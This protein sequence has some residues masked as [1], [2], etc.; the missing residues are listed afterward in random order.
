M[1]LFQKKHTCKSSVLLIM[2]LSF[3]AS[4]L[5][6]QYNLVPNYSFED[7]VKCPKFT[8]NP[9]PKPWY[10]PSK[11]QNQNGIFLHACSLDTLAGVPYN[12]Y[13]IGQSYQPAKTGNGYAIPTWEGSGQNQRSYL[14]IKLKDSLKAGTCYYCEFWVSLPNLSKRAC[15]NI[16]LLLTNSALYVD[17]IIHPLGISPILAN[18]QIFN[19]GNP[20][21][22]DTFNWMKIRQRIY[23]Y[24]G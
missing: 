17:T 15:N 16:A 11:Q 10:V 5:V 19:F 20:I 21:M 14:Q 18:P 4:H 1:S 3:C 12:Y 22:T 2:M 23:C 9:P 6:A 24:R 8:D 13:G 7:S